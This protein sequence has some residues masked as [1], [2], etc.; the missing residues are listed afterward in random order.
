M[1]GGFNG[2]TLASVR[3][4]GW[5]LAAGAALAAFLAAD[6]DVLRLGRRAPPVW[7]SMWAGRGFWRCWRRLCWRGRR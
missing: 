3:S 5:Y 4:A 7:A 1:L 6:L 2:V